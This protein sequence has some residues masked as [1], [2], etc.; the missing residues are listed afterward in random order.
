LQ[1]YTLT[2]T[3]TTRILASKYPVEVGRPG[4]DAELQ[5]I[6]NGTVSYGRVDRMVIIT[7]PLHDRNGEY[8]AAMRVKLKPF[9]GETQ[10][11]AVTRARMVQ[12]NLEQLC[13]AA[14][15]LQN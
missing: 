1:I 15:N 9:F 11:S 10:D 13:P 8:I 7:M 5:A 12:K 6:E 4:T 14:E 3:N 2:G